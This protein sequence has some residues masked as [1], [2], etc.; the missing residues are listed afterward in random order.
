M[1]RVA[2]GSGPT[3]ET[4]EVAAATTATADGLPAP[5]ASPRIEGRSPMRLA[6]ERLR[7]AFETSG[8][9]V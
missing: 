6:M 2:P 5:E 7:Q 3:P 4:E 8:A 1:A 9:G